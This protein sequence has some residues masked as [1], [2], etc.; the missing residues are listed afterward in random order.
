MRFV[1]SKVVKSWPC[2]S[3]SLSDCF[4]ALTVVSCRFVLSME[5]CWTCNDWCCQQSSIADGHGGTCNLWW[6]PVDEWFCQGCFSATTT[7]SRSGPSVRAITAWSLQ[8]MSW[9]GC[10]PSAGFLKKHFESLPVS[11]DLANIIRYSDCYQTAMAN[12]HLDVSDKM[13]LSVEAA[14]FF[15]GPLM[16]NL[17]VETR[18]DMPRSTM[19]VK[20]P[21]ITPWLVITIAWCQQGINQHSRAEGAITM[22]ISCNLESF[23][24]DVC[25][26]PELYHE[27]ANHLQ[28]EF[29]QLGGQ[30]GMFHSDHGV[31][32]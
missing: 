30:P 31:L 2:I 27:C 7:V 4:T 25:G 24:W 11:K 18:T 32:P 6:V 29:G 8:A 14:E 28:L 5:K 10:V 16:H 15:S 20:F 12:A 3:A 17:V 21:R 9:F 13:Y 1:G 19:C 23:Q 22:M 26:I